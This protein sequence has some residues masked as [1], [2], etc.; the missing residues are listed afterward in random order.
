MF[1]VLLLLVVAVLAGCIAPLPP[2]P[3]EIEAKRFEAVPGKAVIYLVRGNPDLS[4]EAGTVS[5]DD[6]MM[7]STYPGT[8][9]RW[10]VEPGRHQIRGF[11]GDNGGIVIDVLPDRVYYVQHSYWRGFAGFG[12]SYFR[13]IP[14]PYGRD[15]VMRAELAGG[16]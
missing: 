3:Q 4:L 6:A 8:F 2:S 5:L 15:A 12:Q 10:V 13:L 11:A 7:G 16:R 14:E 1:R 9:F